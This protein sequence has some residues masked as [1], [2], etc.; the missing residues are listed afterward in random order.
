MTINNPTTKKNLSAFITLTMKKGEEEGLNKDQ[1][2][3][4]YTNAISVFFF[5]DLEKLAKVTRETVKY[6]WCVLNP[7][8]Y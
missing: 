1:L 7:A 6:F 2:D 4:L 8:Y 3:N 5:N